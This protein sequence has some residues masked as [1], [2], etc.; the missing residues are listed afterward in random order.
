V[1]L[2]GM[3]L[4]EVTTPGGTATS[5]TD[6]TVTGTTPPP[7]VVT[8]ALTLKLSGLTSGAL[9]LGKRLTAKGSVTPSSLVGN[10]VALTVQ[11]KSGRKWR[12][13]TTVARTIGTGGT[14]QPEVQAHQGRQLPH[15]SHDRQDGRQHGVADVQDEVSPHEG[16]KG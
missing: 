4:I 2:E 9:K 8:P 10:K 7:N 11:H 3:G 14:Y 15:P 16:T 12:T 5:A 13:V 1:N 6:F